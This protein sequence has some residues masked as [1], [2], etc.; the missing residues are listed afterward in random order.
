[1]Q[2]PVWCDIIPDFAG[3]NHC[4]GYLSRLAAQQG[5]MQAWQLSVL[6]PEHRTENKIIRGKT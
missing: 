3:R 2:N 4:Q 1:M 6:R 5:W